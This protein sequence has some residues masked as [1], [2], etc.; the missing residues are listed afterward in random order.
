ME[1]W[2]PLCSIQPHANALALNH[3]IW[4]TFTV[5]I[6]SWKACLMINQ[7]LPQC[8][9]R[10]HSVQNEACHLA[11]Q[12]RL[13]MPL[14]SQS[15]RHRKSDSSLQ[16]EA[17]RPLSFSTAWTCLWVRAFCSS[18]SYITTHTQVASEALILSMSDLRKYKSSRVAC[19]PRYCSM[20]IDNWL[21]F[22][23]DFNIL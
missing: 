8:A 2:L 9:V 6:V 23:S 12:Y 14:L 5:K 1:T 4:N 22:I 13:R 7:R 18:N 20:Y 21:W 10:P 19:L 16:S 3:I 17:Q 15:L 11:W